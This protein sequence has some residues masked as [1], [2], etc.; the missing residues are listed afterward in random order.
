MP[1][2]FIRVLETAPDICRQLDRLPA[3]QGLQIVHEPDWDQ[4]LERLRNET[5]RLVVA[6]LRAEPTRGPGSKCWP[7][8]PALRR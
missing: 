3:A 6:D 4:A 7:R 8:P 5:T 1:D 2:G